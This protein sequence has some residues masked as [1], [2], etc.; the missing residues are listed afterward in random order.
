[1]LLVS[2][3][4]EENITSKRIKT[5]VLLQRVRS[6]TPEPPFDQS[7]GERWLRLACRPIAAVSYD[8]CRRYGDRSEQSLAIICCVAN[9]LALILRSLWNSSALFL[10]LIHICSNS[11]AFP[12]YPH[13]YLLLTT[14]ISPSV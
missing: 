4:I 7:P 13:V 9:I 1:M 8:D 5:Q 10:H 3:N 11:L 12:V 2:N 6:K 14:R